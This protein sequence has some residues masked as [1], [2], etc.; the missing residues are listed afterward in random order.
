VTIGFNAQYLLDFLNN[1]SAEEILFEFKDEQSP[2]LMKPAKGDGYD[3][4]YV[5]MPMRLL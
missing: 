4:K 2:A 5:V 3:Y 1:L